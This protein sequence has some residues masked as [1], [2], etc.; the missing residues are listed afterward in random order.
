MNPDILSGISAIIVALLFFRKGK[1]QRYGLIIWNVA[2]LLLLANI[3]FHAAFSIPTAFQ[4]FGFEQPNVGILYFPYIW[5]PCCVVPIVL[6][7]HLASLRQL[8]RM[9]K[10]VD[11]PHQ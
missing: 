2:C 7:S 8:A 5:L 1:I 4:K 10:K 9:G 11:I 6:L 3:V